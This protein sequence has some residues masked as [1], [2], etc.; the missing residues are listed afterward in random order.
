MGWIPVARLGHP[1][2]LSAE[3][4]S[5]DKARGERRKYGLCRI[6]TNVGFPVLLQRARTRP[7]FTVCLLRLFAEFVHLGFR[8]LAEFLGFRA[9]LVAELAGL[10]FRG[11]FQFIRCF[12]G[13]CLGGFKTWFVVDSLVFWV[14]SSGM[15]LDFFLDL[16]M[17]C[18]RRFTRSDASSESLSMS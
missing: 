5:D 16:R 15:A 11:G 10:G 13:V 7:S 12:L 1:R 18:E 3:Q 9:G 17:F 2:E 6:L 8:C 4:Q 14:G